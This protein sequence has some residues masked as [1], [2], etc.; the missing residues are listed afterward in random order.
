MNWL[1]HELGKMDVSVS[2]TKGIQASGKIDNMTLGPL[3]LKNN[4]FSLKAPP[5]GLPDLKI[6][7]DI[8]LLGAVSERFHVKFSKKGIDMSAHIGAGSA[9]DITA[10][11]KLSGIDMGLKKPDFK[12]ADFGISG[13]IKLDVKRFISGP[14]QAALND[15]FNGL[16]AVFKTGEK[17]VKTAEHNL[18]WVISKLNEARAKVRREKA[19]VEGRVQGAENRV[20]GLRGR[21]SSR[22][23]SY[24]H[25]HGIFKWACRGRE[26]IRI[27]WTE[28]EI[29]IADAA[30]NL[31]RSLISHFPI[32][33]D[34]TVGALI[35]SRDGAKETLLLAEK[36]IEGLDSLSNFMKKATAKLTKALSNAADINIKKASFNGDVQG[37]IRHDAPVDLAIDVVLFGVEIKDRFAF[38]IKNIGQDLGAT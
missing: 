7:S 31:A 36:A 35:L 18:N 26:G 13:D 23:R 15:V 1:G 27:A 10:Q 29:G 8:K 2:P 3:Q 28:G 6:Y 33:L 25:C 34:P 4:D 24:H 22:W 19:A 11:L 5:T 21:L 14:A 20:N 9:A 12:K 38:K 32:D 17:A 16:N 30:L 37:I